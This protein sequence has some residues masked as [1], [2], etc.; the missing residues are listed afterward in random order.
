MRK[1]RLLKF[2]M[3]GL[4]VVIVSFA[5]L[6]YAL[7]VTEKREVLLTTSFKLDEGEKRFI[8]VYV[9]APM[10]TVDVTVNVSKGT[11]K[12]QPYPDGRRFEESL[13]YVEKRINET[14]VE[15]VQYWMLEV[16]NETTGCASTPNFEN[17]V[18]YLYFL[19]EDSYEKEVN[20]E[21][22]KVWNSQNYQDW[23]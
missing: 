11:V 4:L 17:N 13:G 7:T 21:V 18:W 23:M 2:G 12:F 15:M 20:L 19:N 6:A 8:A 16:E 5:T 10:D 3:F 22:S 14:S 1:M 9:P